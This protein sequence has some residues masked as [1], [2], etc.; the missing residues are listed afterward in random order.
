MDPLKDY[1]RGIHPARSV[2]VIVAS[3]A[4]IPNLLNWLIS[5][6]FVSD[7][8]LENVLTI[9]FSATRTVYEMLAKRGI[10]CILVRLKSVVVGWSH[11]V[12]TVWMTRLAL[13]RLLNYWGYDVQHFD[14]D[15]VVL[16]NPQPLFDHYRE[17]DI[18]GSRGRLSKSDNDMWGFA[19]C[20]G[21]VLFRSTPRT[22][23]EVNYS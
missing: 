1:L 3:N 22:G 7:P 17:Y 18:V 8:P 11:G 9:V 6:K 23:E 20:M 16:R 14:T 19:I 4:Y 15:A 21:A 2:T 12:G 10:P 5:A 13:I